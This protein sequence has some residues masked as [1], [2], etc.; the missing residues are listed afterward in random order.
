VLV[1]CWSSASV[2]YINSQVYEDLRVFDGDLFHLA[3][4]SEKKDILEYILQ[5]TLGD[6]VKLE[7]DNPEFFEELTTNDRLHTQLKVHS[8]SLGEFQV[9]IRNIK[10]GA[11]FD[12]KAAKDEYDRI[13]LYYQ[14]VS[15]YYTQK[16]PSFYHYRIVP[17]DE[18]HVPNHVFDCQEYM[19]NF[20]LKV[21]F[22]C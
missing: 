12:V 11:Y 6:Q 10:R 8:K 9:R 17:E 4:P 16:C 15:K 3:D 2:D 14:Y 20:F 18:N 7:K 1:P 5:S 22:K 13:S 19:G 21:I